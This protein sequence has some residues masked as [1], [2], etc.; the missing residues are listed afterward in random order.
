[1]RAAAEILEDLGLYTGRVSSQILV[2]RDLKTKDQTKF[3]RDE[4]TA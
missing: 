3:L 4:G 1:M 2:F